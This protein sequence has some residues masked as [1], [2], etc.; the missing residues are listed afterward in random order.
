[1]STF[2]SDIANEGTDSRQGGGGGFQSSNNRLA[3]TSVLREA[4]NEV[5]NMIT[6]VSPS[7]F[8]TLF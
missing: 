6:K 8:I 4:E 5:I 3:Q 7:E 1:M 2:D